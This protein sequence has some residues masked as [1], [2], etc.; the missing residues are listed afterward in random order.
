M[1]RPGA[2][3]RRTPGP[4]KRGNP[5]LGARLGRWSTRALAIRSDGTDEG[6]AY[7]APHPPK[8]VGFTGRRRHLMQRRSLGSPPAPYAAAF[9][10]VSAVGRRAFTLPTN[11]VPG[12]TEPRVHASEPS[13]AGRRSPAEG[14]AA[15]RA[16]LK[17]R[18][19]SLRRRRGLR[20]QARP[21]FLAPC[22]VASGR[23]SFG[24]VRALGVAGCGAGSA[25]SVLI[26]ETRLPMGLPHAAAAWSERMHDSSF[27]GS[28]GIGISLADESRLHD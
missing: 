4:P 11:L 13:R 2:G 9:A 7:A 8:R 19:G 1:P 6:S 5:E 18:G 17:R 27:V 3:N 23:A 20:P 24:S 25:P 10:R 22:H 26:Q 12:A 28:A 21:W 14:P 16:R 15:R